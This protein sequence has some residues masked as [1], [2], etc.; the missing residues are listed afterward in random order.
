[1]S[2]ALKVLLPTNF[3]VQ[4]NYAQILLERLSQK[5]QLEVHLAHVLPL[6]ETVSILP[7]GQIQTCGE[8]DFGFVELQRDLTL[9]KLKA[10]EGAFHGHH[11]LIGP[12]VE[13][14]VDFAEQNAF[15]LIVMGT[16]GSNGL[17]EKLVGSKTQNVVR[18]SK[19]PVLSLM[20]DRSD[21]MPNEVLL[22]HQFDKE[23]VHLPAATLAIIQAFKSNVHLLEFIDTPQ[24]EEAVLQAMRAFAQKE[25]L[26]QVQF[27]TLVEKDVEQGVLHF[28]QMKN[29]D[30]LLIGTHA[31]SRLFHKSATQSLVNHLFKPMLTFHI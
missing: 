21:W 4:A 9:Q 1:M 14:V 11:I 31:K 3:S 5:V 6:P 2:K 22:A 30:M 23:E 15:D 29:V 13:S 27:H 19:V 20:C 7:D 12:S 10:V 8:I 26:E 28:D 18:Q 17:V 16:K 24:Q 25:G